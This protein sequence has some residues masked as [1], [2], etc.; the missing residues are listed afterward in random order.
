MGRE[1]TFSIQHE[2]LTFFEKFANIKH[3]LGLAH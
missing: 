3:N 2:S 1:K